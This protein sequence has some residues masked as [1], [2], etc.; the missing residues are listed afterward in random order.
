L[1]PPRKGDLIGNVISQWFVK[2]SLRKIQNRLP[3]WTFWA[4]PVKSAHPSE[5]Y[6]FEIRDDSKWNEPGPIR[7]APICRMDADS[8]P[9]RF[10][11]GNHPPKTARSNL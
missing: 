7:S 11:F 1:Q 3:D 2:M 10:K 9:L 6:R 4:P 5:V 8:K